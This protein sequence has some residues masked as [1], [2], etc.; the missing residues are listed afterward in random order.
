MVAHTSRFLATTAAAL[1]ALTVASPALADDQFPA[2]VAHGAERLKPLSPWGLDYA[3]GNCRLARMFGA[4]D[5]RH[6]IIIDQAWPSDAFSLTLAGS[7]FRRYQRGDRVYL[8]LKH[9]V[10]MQRIELPPIGEL[11]D[12][13]PAIII[14]NTYL[15]PEGEEASPSLKRAGLDPVDGS[16]I[17]RV[18][19]ERANRAL[20]FETGNLEDAFAAL[21]TCTDD[22]L[23]EWGLDPQKHRSYQ[24]AEWLN[25]EEIAKR[26]QRRY[27]LTAR[28]RGEQAI[29]KMRVIIDEKGTMTDCEIN[30]ATEAKNLESPACEEMKAAQFK[31]ALDAQG[32]PM[33]SF[34]GT[35]ISYRMSR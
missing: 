14:T 11:G 17:D 1:A 6:L 24:P 23:T 19:I 2:S 26:I 21:N 15:N 18:L 32:S 35:S 13:G 25:P 16:K 28:N 4:E 31:P 22:L 20:S 33:A 34:Y 10:P 5:D 12:F 29:F 7:S 8:G 30:A 9:D 27:P 3:E